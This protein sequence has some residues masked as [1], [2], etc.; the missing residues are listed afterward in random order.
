VLAHHLAQ[1]YA[2]TSYPHF[3]SPLYF[4]TS[5]LHFISPLSAT[6]FLHLK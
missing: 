5:L 6:S 1:V 3:I 4:L 2:L